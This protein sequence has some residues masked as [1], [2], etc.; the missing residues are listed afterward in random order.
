MAPEA[1]SAPVEPRKF[2]TDVIWSA[3]SLV[4]FA[5]SGAV[6]AALTAHGLGAAGRGNLNLITVAVTI[7]SLVCSA[8]SAYALPSLVSS[9]NRVPGPL[10]GAYLAVGGVL[11]A[12]AV[13]GGALVASAFGLSAIQTVLL[14]A[15]ATLLPLSWVRSLTAAIAT[16]ERDFRTLFYGGLIGQVAQLTGGV[17]LLAMGRLTLETAVASTTAGAVL[18]LLVIAA[19]SARHVGPSGLA[20]SLATIRRVLTAG[21]ATMPG[22]LGQSLNYRLDIFFVAALSGAQAVGI[23]GIAVLLSEILFYPSLVISQVLLPRAAR[24]L[25]GKSEPAYRIVLTTTALVAVA[26]FVLAPWLVETVFG[27]EFLEASPAIRLLLPGVL[28]LSFWHLATFEL[29]GRGQLLLMSASAL[30]GVVVT[31]LGD[32]LLVPDYN[33]RGAAAA[34]TL[35]YLATT[36]VVL[37]A[38][39]RQLGYRI[40]DLILVRRSDLALMAEE[41]EALRGAVGRRLR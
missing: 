5:F 36:A 22:V 4:T 14:V 7:A 13:A 10:V 32:V 33:V 1:K 34:A 6:W 30:V 19:R 8:G 20:P 9:G 37:F 26:I 12:F 38:V 39:R 35:G 28:A 2:T 16:V 41:L 24:L 17:L 27:P 21:V 40:R 25:E 11:N 18:T 29:V 3:A 23:Y 15:L 31:L